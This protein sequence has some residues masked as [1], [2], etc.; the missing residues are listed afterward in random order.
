MLRK[1]AIQALEG[2]CAERERR[3]RGVLD[4]GH[5]RAADAGKDAQ[6]RAV[7][8]PVRELR[9]EQEKGGDCSPVT[10]RR[11]SPP[12]PRWCWSK[13]SR[14]RRFR[15]LK[16]ERALSFGRFLSLLLNVCSSEHIGNGPPLSTSTERSR[17]KRAVVTRK[18]RIPSVNCHWQDLGQELSETSVV[19]GERRRTPASGGERTARGGPDR[20]KM[21]CRAF[22]AQVP[23][24]PPRGQ[25][26]PKPEPR[27][28]TFP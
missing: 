5:R 21:G 2:A 17:Q 15:C 20:Q 19:A 16:W 9:A 14:G 12:P 1:P 28:S 10:D 3:V 11:Y 27:K 6:L 4:L 13:S 18:R 23:E 22:A 26:K 7:E 25:R 8:L 24:H